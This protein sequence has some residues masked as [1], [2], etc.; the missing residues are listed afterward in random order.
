MRTFKTLLTTI[1]VLLCSITASAHDFEVDGIYYQ[2]TTEATVEVTFKGDSPSEYN[3]EY[4]GDV[5]IPDKVTYGEVEYSVT[6]ITYQAFYEC[7]ALTS[8]VIPNS[9]TSIGIRAFGGCSNLVSVNIPNGVMDIKTDVFSGCSALAS[10]TIPN[11]VT[12]IGRGAFSGCSVLTSIT[13]PS[14]VTSI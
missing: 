5:E 14:S 6:G 3:N 11:S 10:I 8:V 13:I 9:V 1:A 12:S 2:K 7:S 4:S